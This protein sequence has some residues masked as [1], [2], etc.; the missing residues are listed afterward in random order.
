MSHDPNPPFDDFLHP[1]IE[2]RLLADFIHLKPGE[3]LLDVGCGHGTIALML[4]R[5]Y[6][7]CGEIVGIDIQDKIIREAEQ[8]LQTLLELF[9]SETLSIHFITGDATRLE[10]IDP[11]F[12]IVACNPPFF[13]ANASRLS[14]NR[15]RRLARQDETLTLDALFEC[16]V[17]QLC[18]NGRLVFVIPKARIPEVECISKSYR[19]KVKTMKSYPEIRKRSG[20]IAIIEVVR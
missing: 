14:P 5:R 17:R 18:E 8:N 4:A 7:L 13:P 16:A 3:R 10:R 20:G 19:F 6:P 11:G 15:E 12:D 1:P 9:P 2:S